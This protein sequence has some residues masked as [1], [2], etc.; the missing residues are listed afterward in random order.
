MEQPLPFEPQ[1]PPQPPPPPPQQQ[2]QEEPQPQPQ[3][4]QPQQ[5][6]QQQPQQQ[7][8]P[9]PQQQQQQQQ[10]QQQQHE[11]EEEGLASFMPTHQLAPGGGQAMQPSPP[12]QGERPAEQQLQQRLASP[13]PTEPVPPSAGADAVLHSGQSDLQ[14]ANEGQP[15]AVQQ[16][17]A[18]PMAAAASLSGG[19]SQAH[20]PPSGQREQRE[21]LAEAQE[22]RQGLA[23]PV[24]V[25]QLYPDDS[26]Q[27]EQPAGQL[28]HMQQLL[29]QLRPMLQE[30][31]P[32]MLQEVLREALEP[33]KKGLQK[34][35]ELVVAVTKAAEATAATLAGQVGSMT[36]ELGA[37]QRGVE[38]LG[39][40]RRPG[41]PC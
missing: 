19:R 1:L 27:E 38:A 15:Q 7:Q 26:N 3:P 25:G 21:Q 2:Q 24:P 22:P 14:P 17:L 5:P 31:L 23:R 28:S 9:P 11:A 13:A 4:P 35:E 18:P 16:G 32:G 34:Q 41:L 39:K 40:V 30:M 6:Q 20:L 8:Q 29:G 10:P 33:I 37:V 12:Q 36:A